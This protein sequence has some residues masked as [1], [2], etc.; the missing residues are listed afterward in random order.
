MAQ[1]MGCDG[2]LAGQGL[3][4]KG[5]RF[6]QVE[7]DLRVTVDGPPPFLQLGLQS[8]RFGQEFVCLHKKHIL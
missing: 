5:P 7:P 2:E 6:G 8:L 1:N 4:D 3:L